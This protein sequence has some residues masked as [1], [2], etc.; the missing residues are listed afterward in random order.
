M[1]TDIAKVGDAGKDVRPFA[2]IERAQGPLASEVYERVV[3][4]LLEGRLRP[5]DRLILDRL[6]EELDVSRT[7]IRD[8]LL[9]LREEGVIEAVGRRGYVVASLGKS[10]IEQLYEARNAI[11]GFAAAALAAGDPARVELLRD[12]L[13]QAA[14]SPMRTARES[15]LA[16]RSFHRAVVAALGNPH[17]LVFFDAIWGR[18]VAGWAYHEFFTASPYGEFRKDHEELIAEIFAGDP[19]R[20]REAMTAHIAAGLAAT[21]GS[22]KADAGP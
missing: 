18:A 16:N 21:F 13:E 3:D 4:G 6:A 8:A 11:E 15:F 14:G 2:R 1:S 17:L 7:P 12:A 22:E 9:R 20:A 19:E 5:G 10:E